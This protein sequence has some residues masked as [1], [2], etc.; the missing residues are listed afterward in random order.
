[1]SFTFF[2]NAS[3]TILLQISPPQVSVPSPSLFLSRPTKELGS[4]EHLEMD[5][6]MCKADSA[7][8]AVLVKA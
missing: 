1:M 6:Q 4:E 7:A 2:L 3:P 5:P 8:V